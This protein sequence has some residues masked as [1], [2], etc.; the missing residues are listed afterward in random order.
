MS[1]GNRHYQWPSG[2][3]DKSSSTQQKKEY[4]RDGLVSFE[5]ANKQKYSKKAKTSHQQSQMIS[6]GD[7]SEYQS[8]S[9]AIPSKPY[10]AGR[11]V[12]Y[13]ICINDCVG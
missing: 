9:S 11:G 10:Y 2:E 5:N 13:V 7:G 3:Y 12:N 8:S 6:A 1:T 4:W